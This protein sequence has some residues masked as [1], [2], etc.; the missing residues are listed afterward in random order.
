MKLNYRI[1][2]WGRINTMIDYEELVYKI[3][4]KKSF[5]NVDGCNIAIDILECLEICPFMDVVAKHVGVSVQ[6]VYDSMRY[7]LNAEDFKALLEDLKQKRGQKT[8]TFK[9]ELLKDL[10]EERS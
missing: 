10:K 7:Y 8:D 9:A 2:M 6:A 3:V 1:G 5:A 4:D